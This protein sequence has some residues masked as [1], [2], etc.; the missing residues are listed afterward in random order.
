MFDE[1][2]PITVF[3]IS[4]TIAVFAVLYGV[5]LGLKGFYLVE[6][7]AIYLFRNQDG[8]ELNSTEAMEARAR[9]IYLISGV[10]SCAFLI[11]ASS[12]ILT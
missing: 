7:T 2:I 6:P 5:R 8:S 12:D 1:T 11:D 3:P 4:V 10:V 9:R